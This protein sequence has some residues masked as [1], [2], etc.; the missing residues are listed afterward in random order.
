MASARTVETVDSNCKESSIDSIVLMMQSSHYSQA[1][2]ELPLSP[3][4]LATLRDHNAVVFRSLEF[5]DHP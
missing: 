2:D 1:L 3:D 5:P 4:D